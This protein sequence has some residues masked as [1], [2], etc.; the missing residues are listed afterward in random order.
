MSERD[1]LPNDEEITF[2]LGTGNQSAICGG[3]APIKVVDPT[4]SESRQS[5]GEEDS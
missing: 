3:V 5:K 2:T 4:G 1:T